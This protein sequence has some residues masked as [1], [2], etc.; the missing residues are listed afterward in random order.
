MS[1][2]ISSPGFLLLVLLIL[3]IF[4]FFYLSLY[5]TLSLVR[6]ESRKIQPFTVW[7]LLIPGFKMIWSFI[8]VTG[9]SN[10]I[11]E[12]LLSRDYEVTD[13]PTFFS[14]LL[15]AVSLWF[16]LLVFIIP[17]SQY[18]ILGVAGLLQIIFFIQYWNKVNWYKN[19][20]KSEGTQKS[21]I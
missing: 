20:L 18:W 15:Y 13:R 1:Q 16:D 7:L 3:L 9:I 19:L 5:R 10:S 11:R 8:V 21:D 14:G 2:D 17:Q 6:P 4:V 12:E